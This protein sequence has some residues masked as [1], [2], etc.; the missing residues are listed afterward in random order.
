MRLVVGRSSRSK[1]EKFVGVGDTE[2]LNS[3]VSALG[4]DGG[5]AG[6]VEAVSTPVQAK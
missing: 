6:T 4:Y 3:D 2:L 5:I 1:V